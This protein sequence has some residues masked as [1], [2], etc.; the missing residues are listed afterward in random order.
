M[1][2]FGFS[3]QFCD[4]VLFL[5]K[6]ILSANFCN[7]LIY[8]KENKIKNELKNIL[9]GE[10]LTNTNIETTNNMIT[11]LPI[12]FCWLQGEDSMPSIPKLCLESI[13]KNANGHPVKILTLSNY[14]KYVH[15]PASVESLYCAG[16]ISN[17]HFADV[18][19][20]N[21]LYQQGGF[22]ADATLLV[23]RTLEQYIFE[24]PFFTIRTHPIGNYV[25]KCRWAG[26][27]LAA[28]SG[29]RLMGMLSRIYEIYW[30]KYDCIID[31]L[32]MDYMFD[33]LYEYDIQVQMMIDAVP[34]NNENV[35]SV[36]NIL[37][38]EYS[39]SKLKRLCGDSFLFKLNWKLYTD[40][41]LN[42]TSSNIYHYF[43]EENSK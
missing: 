17:A 1:V 14:K 19:R 35:H 39:D 16:K 20:V 40:E 22:W 15:I 41:E 29:N 4:I 42:T 8:W 18:I 24:L 10:E 6:R 26:F 21:L 38:E 34:Y 31:Y 23:T 12:W 27:C 2:S 7:Q 5:G 28:S 32:L 30:S 37:N 3:L 33:Y 13:R 11:D 43:L 36:C 9:R 25:S